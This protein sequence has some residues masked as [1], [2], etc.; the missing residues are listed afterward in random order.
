MVQ[1][2]N[3]GIGY[4]IQNLANGIKLPSSGIDPNKIFN[5]MANA[6]IQGAMME[7]LLKR[8]EIMAGASAEGAKARARSTYLAALVT[9]NPNMTPGQISQ[10]M[11]V[12]DD[13][14]AGIYT[15]DPAPVEKPPVKGFDFFSWFGDK[16]GGRKKGESAVDEVIRIRDANRAFPEQNV[17]ALQNYNDLL[18]MS[19]FQGIPQGMGSGM[20]SPFNDMGSGYNE[21]ILAP[22]VAKKSKKKE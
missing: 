16:I 8:A 20:A 13:A 17:Q 6:K 10:K 22:I 3:I 7:S 15:T 4:F 1:V 5:T 14:Q 9:D 2:S 21:D 19:G 18:Q 11:K 12:F